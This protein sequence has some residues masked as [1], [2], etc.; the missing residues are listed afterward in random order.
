MGKHF[1]R[2]INDTTFSDRRDTERID[3]E[4]TDAEAALGE[5]GGFR[6]DHLGGLGLRP[7]RSSDGRQP[8]RRARLA[9][10]ERA[11]SR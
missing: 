4:R 10:G 3:T 9:V 5:L 8:T 7:A 2:T 6:P 11:T 1:H